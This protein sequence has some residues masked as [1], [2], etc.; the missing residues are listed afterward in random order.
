MRKEIDELTSKKTWSLV[1]APVGINVVGSR[2]TYRLKRDTHGAIAHYKARLVAQGFTQTH[3][4]DDNDTFAP[5]AKFA[6]TRG[7]LLW[8][9]ST[10]G[11]ST[12]WTS[13]TRI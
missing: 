11:R 10:I 12:R 1:K 3:G 4:I 2:W 6:S 9:P 13:K 7:Y 8:P 5:V